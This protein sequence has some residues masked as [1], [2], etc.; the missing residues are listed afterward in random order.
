MFITSYGN[1][2]EDEAIRPDR[3]IPIDD[4]AVGMWHGKA[5]PDGGMYGN[6]CPRDRA[7]ESVGV[8]PK[9]ADD[10]KKETITNSGG[11]ITPEGT[12]HVATRFPLAANG[13]FPAPV[14]DCCRDLWGVAHGLVS[15]FL[16]LQKVGKLICAGEDIGAE[17]A[18][19]LVDDRHHTKDETC[20]DKQEQ[21][22]EEHADKAG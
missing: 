20:R 14:R 15:A 8:N 1:L 2:L 13:H 12:H 22:Y 3:G 4:D 6:I 18:F 16:M 19:E 11:L 5:A 10:G 17:P 7:P 21:S 9:T